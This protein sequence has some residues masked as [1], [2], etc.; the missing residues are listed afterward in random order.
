VNGAS[1]DGKAGRRG[2]CD[3]HASVRSC[4]P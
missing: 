4:P 3:G 2:R 1:L